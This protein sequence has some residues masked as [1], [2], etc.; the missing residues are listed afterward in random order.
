MSRCISY[1]F[2]NGDFPAIAMLGFREGT[3][4]LGGGFKY[5]LCSTLPG[6]MIH[7]DEYFFEMG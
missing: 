1:F 6:E 3:V 4:F 7:F 5:F 2:H